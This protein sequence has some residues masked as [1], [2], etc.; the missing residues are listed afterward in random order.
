[1]LD[2]F[3]EY[4][5]LIVAIAT[6]IISGVFGLIK[7]FAKKSH[8]TG[9]SQKAIKNK[10]SNINQINGNITITGNITNDIKTLDEE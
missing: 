8:S 4:Q 1:M 9:I 3:K 7:Y 10:R 2:V 6:A 5:P